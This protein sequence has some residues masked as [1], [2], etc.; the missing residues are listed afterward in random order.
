MP[1]AFAN[2]PAR[3]PAAAL[4]VTRG[5]SALGLRNVAGAIPKALWVSPS[6]LHGNHIAQQLAAQPIAGF[7]DALLRD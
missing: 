1:I 7:L 6:D 5:K 3:K 4:C 2:A